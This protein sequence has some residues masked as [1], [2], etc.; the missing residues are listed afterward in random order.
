MMNSIS[1]ISS[2][3][4]FFVYILECVDRS[5][6]TGWTTNL[7]RRLLAHNRGVASKYTRVRLPVRMV[8]FESVGS[9]SEAMR[10]ECRIKD[11][12]RTEKLNLIAGASRG[13]CLESQASSL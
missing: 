6:Y 9:K 4:G 1:K 2:E 11:L 12:K 7:K 5:L 10:E 13:G 3:D 8:Y